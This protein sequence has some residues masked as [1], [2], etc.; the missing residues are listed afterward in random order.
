MV[1]AHP[2]GPHVVLRSRAHERK[3]GEQ[4]TMLDGKLRLAHRIQRRRRDRV[5]PQ[6]TVALLRRVPEEQLPLLVLADGERTLRPRNAWHEERQERR[7]QHGHV[8]TY[9]DR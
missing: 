7:P 5:D 9:Q 1:S 8:A 4:R 6:S 3:D 2:P